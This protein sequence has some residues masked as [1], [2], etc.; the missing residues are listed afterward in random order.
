MDAKN[1]EIDEIREELTT[2]KRTFTEKNEAMREQLSLV[3]D[4]LVKS[5]LGNDHETALTDQKIEY[6]DKK[7]QELMSMLT[8][9]NKSF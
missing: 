4:E 3:K 7:I 6:Q 2:E 9:T 1:K 5:Q 8:E